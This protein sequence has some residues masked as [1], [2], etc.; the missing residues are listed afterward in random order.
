MTYDTPA[1]E[2]PALARYAYFF[3]VLF[4]F[5]LPITHT[6]ALRSICL[7]AALILA[8]SVW[9]RERS[10]P[11]P[12]YLV[13]ALALWAGIAALS[14]A[15]SIDFDYSEGEFRNEVG[16]T[17]ASFFVFYALTR[18]ERD[19]DLWLKVLSA[20]ALL[21]AA[22]GI[23]NY[24]VHG[25][26]YTRARIGDHNAY[27]TYAVLVVPIL[28]AAVLREGIGPWWKVLGSAATFLTLVAGA[29]TLNRIMWPALF[30]TGLV[31]FTLI[32]SRTLSRRQRIAGAGV[33]AA[34]LLIGAGMLLVR[35][36]PMPD[37]GNNA[38][39]AALGKI[40]NDPRVVIW[41]YAGERIAE[42]PLTGYGFG[43]GIL[44]RDFRAHFD[45]PL[46]WH[47]H[48][49]FVNHALAGG[50]GLAAALALVGVAFAV[51]FARLRRSDTASVRLAGVLGIALLTA[52]LV[53]TMTDDVLVRETSLLLWAA[54][55]ATL[56]YGSRRA[57]RS[58]PIADA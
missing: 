55:G 48:N 4:L 16:Y 21:I 23:L 24:F 19:Y 39:A 15:W 20:S 27:S 11:P 46:H 22:Y 58:T 5:I 50:V 18:T 40:E 33:L 2:L 42:R 36:G 25:Y 7:G 6:V 51:A 30:L 41:A 35:S 14:L 9:V 31:A 29:L 53:K 37:R 45:N 44:R 12:R 32:A 43:R 3:P 10:P 52:S 13:A 26:W 38:A 49:M 28:V 1:R 17:L 56:G 8:I 34:L 54:L 47:G 57:A